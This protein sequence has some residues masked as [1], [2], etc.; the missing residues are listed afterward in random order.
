M[1]TTPVTVENLLGLHA[2]AAN[3]LVQSAMQFTSKIELEDPASGRRADAKSI[4]QL[5]MM[6]AGKGTGL[7]LHI[8]GS[9]QDAAITALTLLFNNGFGEPCG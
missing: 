1:I 9:D 5:L 2:R 3:I 4:M 6:A 8:E 7:N